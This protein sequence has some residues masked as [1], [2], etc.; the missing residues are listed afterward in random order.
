MEAPWAPAAWSAG[1]P[2]VVRG[3]SPPLTSARLS[4]HCRVF[5]RPVGHPWE[6]DETPRA[7]SPALHLAAEVKGT[8]KSKDGGNRV[9][10]KSHG[11]RDTRRPSNDLSAASER[12]KR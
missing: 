5:E 9:P 6:V 3:A 8:Q 2:A 12:G 1:L 11:Q 4:S 7:G 10:A